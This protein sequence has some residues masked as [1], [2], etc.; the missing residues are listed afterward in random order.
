MTYYCFIHWEIREQGRNMC[1]SLAAFE[2]GSWTKPLLGR[3]P[4][5]QM[6]TKLTYDQKHCWQDT[7]EDR[8]YL[9]S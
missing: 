2:P 7:R 6:V 8:E 9:L 5:K 3:V 1:R 4:D